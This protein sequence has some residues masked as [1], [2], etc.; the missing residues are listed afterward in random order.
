[1]PAGVLWTPSVLLTTFSV[2]SSL[3]CGGASWVASPTPL[4]SQTPVQ[5]TAQSAPA[6]TLV[7]T[8][9]SASWVVPQH[10]SSC[11]LVTPQ[12]LTIG[13]R[14]DAGSTFQGRGRQRWFLCA[15]RTTV[16]TGGEVPGAPSVGVLSE[17]AQSGPGSDTERQGWKVVSRHVLL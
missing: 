11:A 13:A 12:T 4:P 2:P 15:S 16:W 8:V 9:L 5:V 3:G 17:L 7:Q 6:M 1:M 14:G 10:S